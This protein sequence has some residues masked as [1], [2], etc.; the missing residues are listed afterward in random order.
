MEFVSNKMPSVRSGLTRNVTAPILTIST[1]AVKTITDF[2]EEMSKVAAISGVSRKDYD[3]F[4]EKAREIGAKMK[5]SATEST[6]A[7]E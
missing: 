2:Y 6:Q 5:L 1:V 4:R 7:F 3:A